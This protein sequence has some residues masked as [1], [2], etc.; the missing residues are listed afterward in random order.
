MR[1]T[2]TDATSPLTEPRDSS[3]TLLSSEER[4]YPPPSAAFLQRVHAW[5]TQYQERRQ[6][7][8][9]RAADIA[10]QH[11]A[12]L[13]FRPAINRGPPRPSPPL[14][15]TS[16]LTTHS[17]LLSYSHVLSHLLSSPSADDPPPFRPQLISA[18]V[19]GRVQRTVVDS[20]LQEEEERRRRESTPWTMSARTR[21]LAEA[22]E[23]R[24]WAA[25]VD[26][27]RKSEALRMLEEEDRQRTFHPHIT[28]ES[29][30]LSAFLPADFFARQ[31]L[32][33]RE[34]ARKEGQ[35]RRQ[36]EAEERATVTFQPVMDF[37]VRREQAMVGRPVDAV[38]RLH[39]AEE[40]RREDWPHD[41]ELRRSARRTYPDCAFIPRINPKSTLLAHVHRSRLRE[42][43]R[44]PSPSTRPSSAAASA[45]AS[46]S[47]QPSVN[48][49]SRLLCLSS[50]TLAQHDAKSAAF[51][52]DLAGVYEDKRAREREDEERDCTFE[53]DTV[54][55]DRAAAEFE[56]RVPG[57]ER[58]MQV[59]RWAEQQRRS[60]AE[61][62]REVFMLDAMEG[63]GRVGHTQVREFHLETDRRGAREQERIQREREARRNRV[64]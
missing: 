11:H 46:S 54:Q 23:R 33:E 18:P 47:F 58:F 17:S 38:H 30:A 57:V 34:E 8:Q 2:L 1:S 64:D 29:R 44:S 31:R 63:Q 9:Q 43:S 37:D 4:Q 50:G 19:A 39:D 56:R 20:G 21:E 41:E 28:D 13:T 16:L 48:P 3:P 24:Q 36:R 27:R 55:W 25:V 45:G 49:R 10:E 59:R 61:R 26:E 60:K 7:H 14:P 35:R 51:Q 62:E 42:P 53:P 15:T 32:L 12:S 52:H 40:K 22:R 5:Q 6:L